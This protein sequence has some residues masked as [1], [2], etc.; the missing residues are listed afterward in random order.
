[1][2]AADAVAMLQRRSIMGQKAR[3]VEYLTL[4]KQGIATA[5]FK[6]STQSCAT[7]IAHT[8]HAGSVCS[9]VSNRHTF[10]QCLPSLLTC[11]TSEL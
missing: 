3:K 5:S 11:D 8:Q 1:M 9:S 10:G 6:C 2:K 4:T 7:M